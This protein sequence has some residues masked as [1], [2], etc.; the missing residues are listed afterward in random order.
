M[1]KIRSAAEEKGYAIVKKI[2]DADNADESFMILQGDQAVKAISFALSNIQSYAKRAPRRSGDIVALLED[3]SD[4]AKKTIEAMSNVFMS[5]STK[6]VP[7]SKVSKDGSSAVL[8]IAT[9]S[10]RVL[11]ASLLPSDLSEDSQTIGCTETSYAKKEYPRTSICLDDVKYR[12]A[13]HIL[14][15]CL[16][17]GARPQPKGKGALER[18]TAS[19]LCQNSRCIN[20]KHLDWQTLRDNQ[21]R[22]GCYGYVMLQKGNKFKFV[23]TLKCT[24]KERCMNFFRVIIK[25]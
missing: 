7:C 12:V 16:E 21:D 8:D 20:P 1:K 2:T 22:C 4:E 11:D 25:D 3:T 5:K 6:I 13:I 15:C 18:I 9:V 23:P 24:H 19:H 17:R 10:N 14:H